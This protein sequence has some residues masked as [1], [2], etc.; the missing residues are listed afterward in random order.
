MHCIVRSVDRSLIDGKA[1]RVV[2]RSPHGEF[3]VMEGHA[4]LLAVLVPGVIRILMDGVDHSI[5]CK[6]GTFNLSEGDAT[7]LVERPYLLEEIE[8]TTIKAEI[9]DLQSK[10]AGT[11]HLEEIAYLEL[12]C[13]V[14]ETYA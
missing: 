7:L 8:P 6:G 3:A 12:L 10:E 11:S 2:A 5:V 9:A 14:K 4:P 1:D 13:R